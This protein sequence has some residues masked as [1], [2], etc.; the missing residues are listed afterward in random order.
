VVLLSFRLQATANYITGNALPVAEAIGLLLGEVMH[1]R[2]STGVAVT[3][4]G[5]WLTLIISESG[6]LSQWHVAAFAYALA[7]AAPAAYTHCAEAL[8][9]LSEALLAVLTVLM[10]SPRH[11]GKCVV[12]GFAA[13][14]TFCS[15]S[16]P[17]VLRA[18]LATSTAVAVSMWL[19]HRERCADVC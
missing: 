6:V 2:W 7:F 12:A 16:G 5:L 17:L 11:R 18:S 4:A 9:E 10:S 14:C 19:L 3:V 13:V 15:V 1:Q 8:K